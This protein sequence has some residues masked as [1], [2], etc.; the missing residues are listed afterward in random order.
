LCSES[1]VSVCRL[2]VTKVY[3]CECLQIAC[4]KSV[5]VWVS[6]ECMLQKLTCVSVWR[7]HAA[8]VDLCECLQTAC[9]KIVLVWVC[10]WLLILTVC[11]LRSY[12]A[13]LTTFVIK[14]KHKLSDVVGIIRLNLC[15]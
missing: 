2:Q 12:S 3:L 8:L 7:L 10:V 4:Y 5:L 14:R 9:Y 1:C 11:A 13:K 15:R 6:A